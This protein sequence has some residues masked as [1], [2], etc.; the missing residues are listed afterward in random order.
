MIGWFDG[1]AGASGDML[2]GAFVGAGVPLEVPSASIG[3]LDL[4]VTL[5]SEQVQR[6]GLDATRIHVEVPDSTVVRHL[7]DILELFAQLDAGVRTIAT[8]VFERL[9]EAEARVHG[10]S[11]DEVHFHEVGALD[12]IADIVGAAACVVH[13]GLDRIHCSALSLGSGSTRGAHGPIPIPAPAVLEV[14]TGV[15]PMQAGPAPFESTTPT[16]AAVLA[17]I[18]DTWCPMPP[19]TVTA[20]GKGLADETAIRSPTSCGSSL[21]ARP[22]AGA[23]SARCDSSSETVEEEFDECVEAG[24]VITPAEGV[25][26]LER[27]EPVE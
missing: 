2:L 18:V 6:A 25:G 21:V 14:L 13:L 17:T 8:A 27:D 19:M 16:G 12:S 7:P 10:T 23:T 9:A 4:G 26:G 11:I 24:V 20:V 15:A 22:D 1:G 5:Y 3:T